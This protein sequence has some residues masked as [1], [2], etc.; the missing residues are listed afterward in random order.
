MNFAKTPQ[1]YRRPAQL[2]KPPKQS[3]K[4]WTA[5]TCVLHCGGRCKSTLPKLV[6]RCG[7]KSPGMCNG[8]TFQIQQQGPRSHY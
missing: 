8:A 5:K 4:N 1:I 7:N 6:Q 2:E 3:P